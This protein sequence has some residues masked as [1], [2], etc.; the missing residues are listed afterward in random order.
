MFRLTVSRGLG[1]LE[2]RRWLPAIL[3]FAAASAHAAGGP[4]TSRKAQVDF[5]VEMA[6]R[7][8]W[9]EALFR[10]ENARRLE[11][12][13][14]SVLNN[15]A[16]CYEAAGRFEEALETYNDALAVE[17]GNRVVKANY[18]RFAEFYQDFR[19]RETKPAA[20]STAPAPGIVPAEPP[21]DPTEPPAPPPVEPPSPAGGSAR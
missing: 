16:V 4:A 2:R 13:D 3:L 19:P 21:A 10:F 17:P 1:W 6:Q 7:G 18:S 12:N 5:G 15:L 14:A 9:S 20:E 11:P 8:L